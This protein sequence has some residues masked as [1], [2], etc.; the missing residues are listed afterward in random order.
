MS[1]SLPG[2]IA[3]GEAFLH[4]RFFEILEIVRR[5]YLKNTLCFTTNAS[6]LEEPFLKK[7]AR[8]RPVQIMVSMHSTKPDLWARIFGRKESEAVRAVQSLDLIKKYRMEVEGTIVPLPGIC[9]WDDIAETYAH[10]ASHGAKSM[11][12]YWP[13]YTVCTPEKVVQEIACSLDEFTAFA[14]RMKSQ[15]PVPLMAFPDMKTP[16]DLPVKRIMAN[17]LRGNLKARGGP[18]RTVVWLT[19]QAAFARLQE[20]VARNGTA[21]PNRHHVVPVPNRT[22]GGNIMVAGLLM[23]PDFIEAGRQ[24][25][26]TWPDTELLLVP[27]MPFDNLCRDLQKHPAY[28]ISEELHIP[29]WLVNEAG[30]FIPLLDRLFLGGERQEGTS[31]QET[32]NSFNAVYRDESAMEKSLDLMDGFPLRTSRGDL[33]REELREELTRE[34]KR[35]PAGKKHLV[36]GF[37]VLDATRGLCIEEWPTGDEA[38]TFRKWTYLVRRSPRWRISEI[39]WGEDLDAMKPPSQNF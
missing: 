16:L 3:E 27:K 25:L 12:L 23:V 33:T 21:V 10:F 6:M 9:G 38:I 34:R 22:Y 20:M 5:K 36:Q 7:L 39:T 26:E 24:A 37:Q 18:Y 11:I 31:L 13:G 30:G 35:I 8:F 28:A 29:V 2:R 17:T 32:M 1:D 15:Y 14:E 4:P 19:S